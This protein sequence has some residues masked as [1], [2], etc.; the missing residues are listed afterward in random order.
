MEGPGRDVD[1]GL[2]ADLGLGG[3][4]GLRGS[5]LAA[6]VGDRKDGTGTVQPELLTMV[7]GV[8]VG[9]GLV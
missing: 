2:E 3:Q 9:N 8:G 6:G 4:V 5:I 7:R 1:K